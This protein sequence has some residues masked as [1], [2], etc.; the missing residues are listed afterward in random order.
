MFCRIIMFIYHLLYDIC[1]IL[2][3][4][5]HIQYPILGSLWSCVVFWVLVKQRASQRRHPEPQ[6]IVL[7]ADRVELQV[8]AKDD[9]P[10]LLEIR[11]AASIKWGGLFSRCSCN[12]SPTISGLYYVPQFLE[13]PSSRLSHF[14][15]LAHMNKAW[16]A[17]SQM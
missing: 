7:R 6:C 1:H 5:Y 14:G 9:R 3:T 4:V 8:E 10:C 16:D 2:N 15:P 13:T 12:Q 11:V 17:G